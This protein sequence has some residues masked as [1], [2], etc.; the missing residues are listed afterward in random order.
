MSDIVDRLR[1]DRNRYS[2]RADIEQQNLR[3]EAADKIEQMLGKVER[4]RYLCRRA[5]W[6]IEEWYAQDQGDVIGDQTAR[7]AA[8]REVAVVRDIDAALAGERDN[9]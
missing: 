9:E 8:H 5:V 1:S 7:E 3:Y 4:L 6:T 2:R